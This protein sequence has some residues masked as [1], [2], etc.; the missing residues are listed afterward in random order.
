MREH[1]LQVTSLFQSLW[2]SWCTELTVF[3]LRSS[4]APVPGC[5]PA[6]PAHTDPDCLNTPG[7]GNLQWVRHPSTI[8]CPTCS[9]WEITLGWYCRSPLWMNACQ[10]F[11]QSDN[12]CSLSDNTEICKGIRK[13]VNTRR[14][15]FSKYLWN[16]CKIF[17]KGHSQCS[18]WKKENYFTSVHCISRN[19]W[20]HLWDGHVLVL[21]CYTI[22]CSHL[23][24]Q[25]QFHL[26]VTF[27]DELKN[28]CFI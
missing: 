26:P 28:L 23:Q 16:N 13:S 2:C 1:I 18:K 6:I 8:R 22:F 4:R 19:N 14:L 10:I 15:P 20:W 9:H 25:Q 21:C 17:A 3:L 27:D 11:F 24:L 12:P 7:P 5:F